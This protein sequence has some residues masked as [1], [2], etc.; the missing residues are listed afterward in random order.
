M[1]LDLVYRYRKQRGVN[2]GSWFVLERWIADAPFR[3]AA[4]PGQSDLDVARGSNAKQILEEHWDNWVTEGDWQWISG[5]GFNAVRIPLG[6]Y[7]LCG[8]DPS[9]LEKTDFADYYDVFC[10]AWA[11]VT[12]AIVSANRYGLGVLIDLHAAPGKQNNDSHGGTS[13]PP[14]FFK[15]RHHQTHTIHVLRTLLISVNQFC[16]SQSPPLCNVIGIELLNEP[17]PPS[18]D[19]LRSWYASAISELS[20]VDPHMPLYIGECWRPHVYADFVKTLNVPNMVV[21][22]HHLYRCFTGEDIQTSAMQHARALAD[23]GGG[24][25]QTLGNIHSGVVVG[26]WSGALNPGSLL[27]EHDEKGHFIRAQL[28]L[29]E[30]TCAGSFFWT[31]KKQHPGDGGWGLYDAVGQNVFPS[32][33]G[34]RIVRPLTEDPGRD[35]AR[36]ALC[37]EAMSRHVQYWDQWP[38][39][40]HHERFAVGF[41]EGFDDAYFFFTTMASPYGALSEIGFKDALARR[42]TNNH[43]AGLWEY[44]HGFSQGA[45]AA[46][47]RFAQSCCEGA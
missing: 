38:G 43:G 23:P 6:Y 31:L 5:R 17:H 30:N 25:R 22:D 26:E 10:G 19:A 12:N 33:V 28:D 39:D 46:R 32:W 18:D 13:H 34:P 9:V 24:T 36:D 1:S 20:R 7:H 4:E 41:V 35:E 8:A 2:L 14:A 42:R 3:G 40:Y 15:H 29:F 45:D 16:Q 37:N 44:V 27:G 47:S 11:R 21:L